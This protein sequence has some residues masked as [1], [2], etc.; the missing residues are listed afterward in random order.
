MKY[1]VPTR[2]QTSEREDEE[3]TWGGRDYG[4]RY[5]RKRKLV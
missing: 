1:V 3:A 4:E 2:E 5:N